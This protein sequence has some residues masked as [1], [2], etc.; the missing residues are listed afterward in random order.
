MFM[1]FSSAFL[2]TAD[3]YRR[4]LIMDM[5]LE[6]RLSNELESNLK[7]TLLNV[8][9]FIDNTRLYESTVWATEKSDPGSCLCNVV[10]FTYRFGWFCY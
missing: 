1:T 2:I 4:D 10:H 5:G 9:H 8:H 7:R 6:T 3:D